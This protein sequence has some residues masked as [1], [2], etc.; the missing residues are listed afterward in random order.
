[1]TASLDENAKKP[2]HFSPPFPQSGGEG[3]WTWWPTLCVRLQFVEIRS[4]FP[5]LID[6]KD[7]VCVF[8]FLVRSYR[9]RQ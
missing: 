4:T 7:P 8:L 6:V 3:T 9:G 5:E 1:M 2:T